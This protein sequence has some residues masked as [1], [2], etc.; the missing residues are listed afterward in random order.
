VRLLRQLYSQLRDG[1]LNLGT[2]PPYGG[3]VFVF[4]QADTIGMLRVRILPRGFLSVS[5]GFSL[6]VLREHVPVARRSLR[7]EVELCGS[8]PVVDA[9]LVCRVYARS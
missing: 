1:Y 7:S 5:S 9:E 3:M 2:M 4:C 6:V 8:D